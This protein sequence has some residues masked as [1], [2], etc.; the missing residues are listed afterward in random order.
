M[1]YRPGTVKNTFWHTSSANPGFHIHIRCKMWHI[2]I[3]YAFFELGCSDNQ[4]IWI[5]GASVLVYILHW[6]NS[7][8]L[9][10]WIF[11]EKRYPLLQFSNLMVEVDSNR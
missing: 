1:I 5:C 4:N 6:M 10:I 2:K 11:D 9:D 3:I 7:N 8:Y